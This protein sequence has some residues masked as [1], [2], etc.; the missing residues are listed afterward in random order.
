VKRRTIL[1][2]L[3]VIPAASL[4]KAQEP[5]VLPKPVAPAVEEIPDLESVTADQAGTT[6]QA[7]FE[8][9]RF[10]TLKRFC[11]VIAPQ[12]GDVPGALAAGA[13]EFLD[14][15]I[16][17]SPESR[18]KLYTDGLDE[19]NRRSERKFQIQ[20]AETNASQADSLL[21]PLRQ[22]WTPEPEDSP[23]PF[24]RA[25]KDDILLATQNSREWV[26]AMS[27]RVR[28]AGGLGMYWYRI[29]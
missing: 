12:S 6:V 23:I 10:A 25:A 28:S 22:P 2:S 8:P 20:F 18:K 14:F 5:V 1:Q 26:R 4:A 9:T 29:E 17:R 19:L 21:E 13:P 15:L 27:K 3:A 24:L 7:F 11:D 16:G